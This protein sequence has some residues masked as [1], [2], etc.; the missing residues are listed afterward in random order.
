M[1]RLIETLFLLLAAASPASGAQAR[2]SWRSEKV[3]GLF[4]CQVPEGW[5]AGKLPGGEAGASYTKG[6]LAIRV[7]RYGPKDPRYPDPEKLLKELQVRPKPGPAPAVSGL[8]AEILSRAYERSLGG[9]DAAPRSEWIYEEV[10]LLREKDRFW[11]VIFRSS[12][13]LPAAEPRGLDVW[14]AFLER[15]SLS[16]SP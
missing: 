7:A 5:K 13:R 11:V 3:E 15:L 8:K 16:R 12:S 2:M 14:K 9:D 10:A 4:S 6:S 1:A